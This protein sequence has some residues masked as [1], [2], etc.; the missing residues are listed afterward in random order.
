MC[1]YCWGNDEDDEGEGICV[2]FHLVSWLII[3]VF[4]VICFSGV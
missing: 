2:L 1:N 4:V 3:I